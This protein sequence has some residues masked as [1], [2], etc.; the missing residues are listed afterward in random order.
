MNKNI[1][2][3]TERYFIGRKSKKHS[4]DYEYILYDCVNHSQITS[5]IFLAFSSNDLDLVKKKFKYLQKKYKR[6]NIIKSTRIL[7]WL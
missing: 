5:N 1:I 7:E 3:K 2:F 6:L 4:I